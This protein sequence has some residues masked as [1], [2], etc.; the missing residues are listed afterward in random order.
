MLF[1]EYLIE[2]KDDALD[3]FK[4]T[5]ILNRPHTFEFLDDEELY[6]RIE[7]PNNH[8]NPSDN[9]DFVILDEETN[10]LYL[11]DKEIGGVM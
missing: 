6:D 9:S 1:Q 11:K 5:Y 8:E 7:K 3:E 2:M 10:K 4:K